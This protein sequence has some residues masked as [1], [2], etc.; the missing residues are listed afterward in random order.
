MALTSIYAGLQDLLAR[1]PNGS[2]TDGN[3]DNSDDIGEVG[4]PYLRITP[5]LERLGHRLQPGMPAELLI[6]TG[7][8]T[9]IAYLAQPLLDSMHKALREQ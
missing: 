8:R 9:P 4:D 5:E 6:K 7:K 2:N 1:E 3:N